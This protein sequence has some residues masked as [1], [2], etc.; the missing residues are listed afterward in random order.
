MSCG[1]ATLSQQHLRKAM[2][3]TQ[4]LAEQSVDGQ[5]FVHGA[6]EQLTGIVA[7]DLTTL[8]VC[9]LSRGTRRVFGRQGEALSDGDRLAF[10]RHFREHPL[11]RYHGDNPDGRTQRISD[12]QNRRAFENSSLFDD[13][14]RRIGIRHVMAMPLRIGNDTVISVVFNRQR[15]DFTDVERDLLDAVRP[16]LGALYRNLV[17]REDASLGLAC[18][19]KVAAD[20]GWHAIA[21]AD[22]VRIVAA[23]TLACQLLTRFFP[24]SRACDGARL[25][26]ALT[27]WLVRSRHWG[28]ELLAMPLGR[29]FTKIRLG[30]RLTGHFLAGGSAPGTGTLMLRA[31]RVGISADHLGGVSARVPLTQR[32]REVLAL[33]AAG[34]TNADI[35]RLLS[36]STRTVQKHLERVFDKL[37]V[38]TRTAAAM[39]ALCSV[40]A[41]S[42]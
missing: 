36:I 39:V 38:D 29:H 25:P 13:Y 2:S 32:E 14:Y 41:P 5:T 11:V 10:D 31:E 42:N 8:S 33:V 1:L 40:E 24:E 19:S 16:L 20:A 4:I 34:K 3:V 23:P 37:G 35:A 7:S 17:A 15:T 18:L 12:C 9:D 6:L 28:L 22:G 30:M 27:D 21:I 26:S